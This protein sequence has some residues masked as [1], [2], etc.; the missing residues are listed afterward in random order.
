ML[1]RINKHKQK[2]FKKYHTTYDIFCYF[3]I[4]RYIDIQT[5]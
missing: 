2:T 5:T 1:D 3:V 4:Y